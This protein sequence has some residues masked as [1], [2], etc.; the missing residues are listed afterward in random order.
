M[1]SIQSL[2]QLYN[3]MNQKHASQTSAEFISFPQEQQVP[4]N[5]INSLDPFN[6]SPV[7]PASPQQ[8]PASALNPF[9][10]MPSPIQ[11][12]LPAP[13]SPSQPQHAEA[14]PVDNPL[15]GQMHMYFDRMTKM[16]MAMD[17]RLT[18]LESLMSHNLYL[19]HQQQQQQQ[20][21]QTQKPKHSQEEDVESALK[22]QVKA[23]LEQLKKAQAQYEKDSD[24]AKKIQAQM[25][26]E[27]FS[28]ERKK[29]Y[30]QPPS[31]TVYQPPKPKVPG[32]E[33]CP[34][35]QMQFKVSELESHV[36]AC[37]DGEKNIKEDGTKKVVDKPGFLARLFGAKTE[38]KSP[39]KVPLV[40]AQAQPA[41]HTPEYPHGIYPN[42][43]TY[44]PM[45][46]MPS[47]P[48]MGAAMP[49]PPMYYYMPPPAHNP[50]Q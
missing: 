31:T 5:N 4:S 16:M 13:P 48:Y 27:Y 8:T 44:P 41:H 24:I 18:R 37:L 15:L 43:A 19:L 7:V 10:S 20:Q 14:K 21:V 28:E 42:M 34:L 23:E 6:P 32:Y 39:E 1:N 40:S 35:C 45:Y 25:D 38:E 17:D 46:P 9:R 11:P 49:P 30:S 47:S 36:Y 12:S 22:E 33:E 29:F 3:E 2:D 26:D 50:G